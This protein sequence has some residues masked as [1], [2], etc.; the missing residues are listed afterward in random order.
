[1]NKDNNKTKRP[2]ITEFLK[3]QDHPCGR[4]LPSGT[5]IP[6][7]RKASEIPFKVLK[8]ATGLPIERVQQTCGFCEMDFINSLTTDT[9]SKALDGL[10]QRQRAISGNLAN[11]DTPNYKRRDVSFEGALNHALKAQRN[12]GEQNLHVRSNDE[13]MGLKTTHAGHFNVGDFNI[14]SLDDVSMDIEEQGNIEY[15][16]DGNSVDVESEMVQLS[17]NTQRYTAITT[18]QS[19]NYRTLKSMINGG[20][21][22]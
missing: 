11:A 8:E 20:G 19:R 13:V 15:R 2:R 12:Q 17:R 7:T 14:K 5:S 16:K 3:Q 10:S 1:V 21:G 4:F 6:W 9:M 18:L 22:G